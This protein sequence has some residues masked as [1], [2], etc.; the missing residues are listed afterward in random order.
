MSVVWVSSVQR[1]AGSAVS[2]KYLREQVSMISTSQL[3]KVL[4]LLLFV[5][6]CTHLS[7][8]SYH[9]FDESSYG[10]H[11]PIETHSEVSKHVPVKVIEKVP[12]SIPHPVPVEVPNV[13]RIQIP[14]PY[15]VHV[16]VEQ[17][18]QV[19]TYNIVPEITEKRIPYTV[20]KP[21]PVEV[22]RP[23][24]VEVVKQ[25]KIPVP[26]PYPVPVT[27]YKHVVQKDH[28]WD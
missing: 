26:K 21:Y 25:I 7:S 10:G 28:G 3:D 11:H 15:A 5:A 12:L 22:E 13:I 1:V 4:P 6:G 18:I 9:G 16:P 23:Y 20:E 24:P 8:A 27:I 19:P 17:E 14:E 2:F